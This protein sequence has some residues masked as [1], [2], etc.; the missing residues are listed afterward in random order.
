VSVGL[1]PVGSLVAGLA[2]DAVGGAVTL[3]VMGSLL[4]VT[5][6]AFALLPAVRRAR[7]AG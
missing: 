2:L 3:A 4:V 7:L 1:M 6:G 5:A